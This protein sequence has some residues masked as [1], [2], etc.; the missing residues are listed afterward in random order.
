M[1][2]ETFSA[3]FLPLPSAI[4]ICMMESLFHSEKLF[5]SIYYVNEDVQQKKTQVRLF[6]QTLSHPSLLYL[7]VGWDELA[8][9]A[10]RKF[11]KFPSSLTLTVLDFS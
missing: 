10:M 1:H 9:L 2:A 11:H 8:E 6:I 7:C 4:T 3:P 5:K